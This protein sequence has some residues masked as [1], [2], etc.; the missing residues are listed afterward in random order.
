MNEV[1]LLKERTYLHV[2]QIQYL[3]PTFVLTF[4]TLTMTCSLGPLTLALF[5]WWEEIK[6]LLDLNGSTPSHSRG[7]WRNLSGPR[8]LILFSLHLDFVIPLVTWF[9]GISVP[10]RSCEP[11][12]D[13]WLISGNLHKCFQGKMIHTLRRVF[14]HR[15][16]Q[17]DA[18]TRST[19]SLGENIAY[20][21]GNWCGFT[22]RLLICW[23]IFKSETQF[24]RSVLE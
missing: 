12:L 10:S 22:K 9:Y 24:M 8:G 20:T 4:C 1:S 2:C 11:S 19:I 23:C 5:I 16:R 21:S 7:I 15:Y 3:K 17:H 13:S 18:N 14:L 6:T